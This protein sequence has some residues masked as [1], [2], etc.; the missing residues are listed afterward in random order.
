MSNNIQTAYE[1]IK[2]F[3]QIA[4]V[5]NGANHEATLNNVELY[6]S[7]IKEE[8]EETY[9]A[10]TTE[11][12]QEVVDG[13]CDMFVVASGLMQVLEASG[14]NIEKALARVCANNLT[15]FPMEHEWVQNEELQPLDATVHT[16]PYGHVVFKRDDGKIM[17]PTNF[18]PVS[19]SGTFPVDFFGPVKQG[20]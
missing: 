14:V 9:D 19:L 7:L 20:K 2:K 12:I 13:A 16:T 5:L 6:L 18:V 15:K 4:G 11:D 3:N 17:K 10:F 8:L 1:Q